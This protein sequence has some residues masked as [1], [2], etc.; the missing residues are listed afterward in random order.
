MVRGGGEE[1]GLGACGWL[2]SEGKGW[3][4]RALSRT[5]RFHHGVQAGAQ[6]LVEERG[7]RRRTISA[8][9]DWGRLR[10]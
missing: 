5:S 4:I 6:R 10:E 2:C 7:R 3:S 8:V 9:F 1:E